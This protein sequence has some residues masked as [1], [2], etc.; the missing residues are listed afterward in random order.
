MSST[1]I[2]H[3]F[4]SLIT[5]LQLLFSNYYFYNYYFPI[6]SRIRIN[7]YFFI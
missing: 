1:L 4:L 7:Q 5:T 3:F 2:F 6:H